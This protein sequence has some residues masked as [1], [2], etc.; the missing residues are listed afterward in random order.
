MWPLSCSL[1]GSQGKRFILGVTLGT[2][3]QGPSGTKRIQPKKAGYVKLDAQNLRKELSLHDL[4][5]VRLVVHLLVSREPKQ[6]TG[7]PTKPIKGHQKGENHLLNPESTWSA[8]DG[9][10]LSQIFLN[11][12]LYFL[13]FPA[14]LQDKKQM[15]LL[16]LEWINSEILLCSTESCVQIL[17]REHENGKKEYV[18][19][20]V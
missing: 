7:T 16:L 19:V 12:S 9:T 5:K 14:N 3:P 8:S 13:L 1:R 6:G 11:P 15:Q 20:Y 18:Y 10:I 4:P 17:T 2:I